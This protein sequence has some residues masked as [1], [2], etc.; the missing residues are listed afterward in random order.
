MSTIVR[1]RKYTDAIVTR[2]LLFPEGAARGA[3]LGTEVCAIDGVT[4][5]SLPD[6]ATLPGSQPEEVADSIETVIL[7]DE[8]RAALKAASPHV[9]LIN[10]RVRATILERYTLEDE[11]QLL[12]TAPSPE[13]AAYNAYVEDCLAWG[14]AEKAKLGL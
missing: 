9:R 3:R 12:R 8:L 2:E 4:Y 14:R 6:K 1:Y 10:D 11:I 5:V 7:T 13:F